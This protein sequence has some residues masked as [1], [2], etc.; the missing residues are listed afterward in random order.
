MSGPFKMK[1]TGGNKSAFPFKGE[2]LK[3]YGGMKDSPMR[4]WWSKMKNFA[5]GVATKAKG[6]VGNVFGGGGGQ[7]GDVGQEGGGMSASTIPQHGPE[8][9]TGGG[10]GAV[11]ESG[12]R[13]M[14]G[15]RGL[16]GEDQGLNA[17]RPWFGAF[18][19]RS[20]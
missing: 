12:R 14:E 5:S 20:A 18:G 15:F 11:E 8:S 4:S 7:E 19:R 1:Y 3:M 6:V 13:A 2:P 10:E 9:H 16:S 17:R